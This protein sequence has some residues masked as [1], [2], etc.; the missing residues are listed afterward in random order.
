MTIMDI[1]YVFYWFA[2]IAMAMAIVFFL[3][4]VVLLFYIKKKVSDM[5]RYVSHV[6]GRMESLMDNVSDQVKTVTNI[7]S[8]I[9]GRFKI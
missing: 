4:L 9:L 7:K 5:D 6:I 3:G 1:Q 2:T 8:A